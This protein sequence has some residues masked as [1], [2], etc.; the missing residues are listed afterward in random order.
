MSPEGHVSVGALMPRAR[1]P[2]GPTPKRILI[3]LD[4]CCRCCCER[5]PWAPKVCHD[6]DPTACGSPC[7]KQEGP[8]KGLPSPGA[9]TLQ[10]KGKMNM[11][12]S[13]DPAL[14]CD[15]EGPGSPAP[16]QG[17]WDSGSLHNSW[18]AGSFGQRSYL[19]PACQ[20]PPLRLGFL[21][22]CLHP[23]LPTGS[24]Y[25]H[26]HPPLAPCFSWWQR[27]PLSALEPLRKCGT[28][29]GQEDIPYS[30]IIIPPTGKF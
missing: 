25:H 10:G 12:A 29:W 24:G 14:D 15:L 13:T 8:G 3:G 17:A 26:S 20:L 27:H 18:S 23:Q 21:R 1:E 6:A 16:A 22:L 7:T 30:T 11:R 5:L 9:L 28:N 19:K 4:S 2:L